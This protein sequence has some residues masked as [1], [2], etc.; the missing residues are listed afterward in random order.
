[1]PVSGQIALLGQMLLIVTR[2]SALECSAQT[3]RGAVRPEAVAFANP[4][5]PEI[6][7]REGIGVDWGRPT[8]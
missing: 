1:V 5:Y 8:K 3:R 4:A 7:G 2:W 6:D